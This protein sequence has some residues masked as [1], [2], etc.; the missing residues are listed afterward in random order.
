MSGD[1]FRLSAVANYGSETGTVWE[2]NCGV[3]TSLGPDSML[4]IICTVSLSLHVSW[5][6]SFC[7]CVE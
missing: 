3:N 7:S 4:S 2:I 6:A 5:V 1:E